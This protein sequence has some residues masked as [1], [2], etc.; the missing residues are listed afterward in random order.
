MA[1]TLELVANR[2]GIIIGQAHKNDK[3]IGFMFRRAT[4]EEQEEDEDAVTKFTVCEGKNAAQI[5]LSLL[6]VLEEQL[7]KGDVVLIPQDESLEKAK[8]LV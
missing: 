4:D 8:N 6:K 5:T 3:V 1:E 7:K 2:L